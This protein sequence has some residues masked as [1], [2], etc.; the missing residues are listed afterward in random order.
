MGKEL[1]LL[2]GGP[3]GNQKIVSVID[4]TDEG[5]DYVIADISR[6]GSW[7]SVAESD[8]VLLNDYR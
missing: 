3:S 6:D 2:A 4:E 1:G 5:R 8:T 7:I